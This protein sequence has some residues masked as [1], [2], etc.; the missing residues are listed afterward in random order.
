MYFCFY[1]DSNAYALQQVQK[2]CN[3]GAQWDQNKCS[4]G[5]KHDKRSQILPCGPLNV[6]II[7]ICTQLHVNR[8]YRGMFLVIGRE[9]QLH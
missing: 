6:L 5:E 1:G 8:N 9:K 4:F 2:I 3:E 7:S